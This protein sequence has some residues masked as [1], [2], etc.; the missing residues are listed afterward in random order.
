[1]ITSRMSIILFLTTIVTL[2]GLSPV[3]ASSQLEVTIEPNS[4]TA[5]AK[6]V[7]QRNISIDYSQGGNLADTLKGKSDKIAFSF[8]L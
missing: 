8:N 6:M 4:N 3:L 7:Y 5:V 1:M 2:S